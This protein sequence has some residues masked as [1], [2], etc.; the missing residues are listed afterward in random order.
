MIIFLPYFDYTEPE[1]FI[2]TKPKQSKWEKQ[3]NN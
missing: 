3:N 1:P 2:D